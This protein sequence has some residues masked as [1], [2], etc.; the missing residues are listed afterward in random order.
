MNNKSCSRVRLT[1]G[2][3][4]RDLVA[5]TAVAVV[6]LMWSAPA[7]ADVPA[8]MRSVASNPLPKY[9]AETNAVLLYDET[10]IAVKDAGEVHSIHRRV[11]RILRPSGR[12][13]GVFNVSFD[14]ETKVI[15]MRAWSLPAN[16]GKEFEVKEKDAVET[17]LTEGDLYSD[18][19]HRILRIPAAD[20]GATVAYEY[21]QRERPYILQ[22]IWWFQSADPVRQSRFILQLP[23]GWRYKA[24]WIHHDAVAPQE[25][26]NNQLH[27]DLADISAVEEEAEMPPVQSIEGRMVDNY[28]PAAGT[29]GNSMDSWQDVGKWYTALTGDRRISSVEIKKKVEDLAGGSAETLGKLRA[30]AGFVQKDI[31]YVAIEIGVGGYQPHPAASVFSNR[32][33]DCKDKAT[34][35]AAMLHEIGIDSFYVLV[36]TRRG[37]VTPEYPPGVNFNH[38]ILAITLPSDASAGDLYAIVA[39]PRYGKLLLF[40]P[41]STLTPLGDLPFYEQSNYGMLTAADGGE[42][43]RMPLL[44]PSVNRLSRTARLTLS[45]D[46]SITG[47]VE[48]LRNGDPAESSRARLLAAQ[49]GERAKVLE[50]FIGS[51]VGGFTLTKATVGNLEAYDQMLILNY[52]FVAPNYAQTAGN[53]L[54]VRPRVLGEKASTLLEEKER[55]YP[56]EFDTATLQTDQ[57]DLTL[58]QGYVPDELPPPVR[59]DFDFATYSSKVEMVSGNVLRYS[60]TYQVKEVVVPSS[61]LGDLKRFYRQILTDESSAAVFKKAGS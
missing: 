38:V 15:S 37:V 5:F 8:W 43:V 33:G 51:S 49:G 36:N 7:R 4:T 26:G 29:V 28:F 60:R 39:H 35:L 9:S 57:F 32:Y 1:K 46:G 56:V 30:L 52:Q 24:A 25:D 47:S 2:N 19:R 12:D 16:G 18:T 54:L 14:K 50:S 23:L 40:D 41:T 21:E 45:P 6:A 27:W 3:R 20:P 11:Y 58:P 17:Q 61:R 10:T 55:K 13:R 44:P 59:I 53:L 22:D 42:L 34:L 31:R 48:E